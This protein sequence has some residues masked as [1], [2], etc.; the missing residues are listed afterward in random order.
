MCRFVGFVFNRL[1]LCANRSGLLKWLELFLFV[2]VEDF[3]FGVHDI[4]LLGLRFGGGF[5]FLFRSGAG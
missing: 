3:E 1:R 5:A 4:V 2:F